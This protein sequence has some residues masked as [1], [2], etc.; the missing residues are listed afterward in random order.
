MPAQAGIH[1]SR[2]EYWIPAFAGMTAGERVDRFDAARRE[3]MGLAAGAEDVAALE[4]AKL[5]LDGKGRGKKK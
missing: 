2:A 1:L 3:A 4:Q 5:A